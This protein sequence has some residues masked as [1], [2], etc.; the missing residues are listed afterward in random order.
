MANNERRNIPASEEA[1]QEFARRLRQGCRDSGL[2]PKQLRD[3]AGIAR[4]TMTGYLRGSQYPRREKLEAVA[5]VLR[6]SPDWLGAVD[7]LADGYAQYDADRT[8]QQKLFAARLQEALDASGRTK[9]DVFRAAGLTVRRASRYLRGDYLP[10]KST[11][12]LLAEELGVSAAWLA[13]DRERR[14]DD[15]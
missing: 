5:A 7:L 1:K 13:G 2:T 8:A 4:V 6:V 15:E 14:K 12:E 9:G 11:I 3:A 10:Y